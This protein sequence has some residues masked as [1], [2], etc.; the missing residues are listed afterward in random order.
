MLQ[1]G[2][3][4]WLRGGLQQGIPSRSELAREVCRKDDWHNPRGEPLYCLCAQEPAAT[5]LPA[6]PAAFA[7]S[8]LL[9]GLPSTGLPIGPAPVQLR[10]SL[11]RLDEFLL[12]LA[13]TPARRG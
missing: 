13:D 7:R 11:S 8:T 12:L 1:P 6:G 4:E 5:G 9:G 10:G 2:T 3:V